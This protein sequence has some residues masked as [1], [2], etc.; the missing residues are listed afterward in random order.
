[1]WPHREVFPLPLVLHKR[2]EVFDASV[3]GARALLHKGELRALGQKSGARFYADFDAHAADAVP[4]VIAEFG[5]KRG[6]W[7]AFLHSLRAPLPAVEYDE[8]HKFLVGRG[9]REE[10]DRSV[11]LELLE[12]MASIAQE[13]RNE[14]LANTGVP[15]RPLLAWCVRGSDPVGGVYTPSEVA[16]PFALC[17]WAMRPDPRS[18]AGA[19]N[20]EGGGGG[21][22]GGAAAAAGGAAGEASKG[23]AAAVERS[24]TSTSTTSTSTSR[25]G[26]AASNAGSAV[27]GRSRP[28]TAIDDETSPAALEALELGLLADSVAVDLILDTGASQME[29]EQLFNMTGATKNFAKV[30]A[31]CYVPR[32]FLY[33]VSQMSSSISPIFAIP[34]IE[35]NVPP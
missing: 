8:A 12:E 30:D 3:F 29:R 34:G 15:M 17:R 6:R 33:R 24:S 18:T 26:T 1:M 28:A 32:V 9:L 11:S 31:G 21:G 7:K 13:S 14:H 20:A 19:N 23:R 4:Q 16:P 5:A 35:I 25:P 22:G 27:G 2:I 10:S